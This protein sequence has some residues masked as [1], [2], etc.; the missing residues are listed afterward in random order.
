MRDVGIIADEK[1][2]TVSYE[3]EAEGHNNCE[4]AMLEDSP[5]SGA[6]HILDM[7]NTI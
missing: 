5:L 4:P 6:Q 7:A 1:R 2:T 3:N